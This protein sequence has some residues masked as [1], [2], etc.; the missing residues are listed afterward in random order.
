MFEDIKILKNETNEIYTIL[1]ELETL[2]TGEGVDYGD[3]ITD[4][5]FSKVMLRNRLHDLRRRKDAKGNVQEK[6]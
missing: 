1:M 4:I 2:E 5:A 3:V 6:G